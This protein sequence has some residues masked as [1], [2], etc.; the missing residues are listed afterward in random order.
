MGYLGLIIGYLII[1]LTPV[2]G[3]WQKAYPRMEKKST[4]AF[5][6]FYNYFVLLRACKLPWY[7]VIFL[8]FP[9]VQFIM[10]AALNV[11]YIR[12]F[13]EFGVKETILGILFPYPV[14]WKI[15]KNP[16]QYKVVPP[17]N[18]EVAKQVDART[19]SDHVALFFALP[20][21]GHAIAYP[22]SLLGV[23]KKE[24]K[25]SIFKEWGDA[26]LFAVIA[27]SVI[28]TY[29]FEPYKIPTGSME[30]T[31]LVG[32]HL[33]VDKLTFGPRVPMTPFSY[34]IVHN[35]FAP[36][37]NI[38]SYTTL[39]TIPYT[40]L[41]GWRDVERYDVVV[42]NFPAGDTAIND[43]R[44]PNG[45]I[46]HTYGQVLVD[47]AFYMAKWNRREFESRKSYY[48][49]KA[50]KQIR[51]EKLVLSNIEGVQ[52]DRNAPNGV[53][54][55][56]GIKMEG[57]GSGLLSRPVDKKE[58]Y[59]KRCVGLPGDLL[60][61]VN[62]VLYVNSK[63]AT[64][65]PGMQ[66]SG[67]PLPKGYYHFVADSIPFLP[68]YTDAKYFPIFPNDPQYDWTEDNFGPLKIP[69]AG[70]VVE[71]NHKTYPIYK[72]IIHAYEGH[73]LEEKADGIYIDG[74][75][76]DTY[77]IEMNYYWLMG[78]NRNN[79]ADSRFWGFVPEDH[80]VGHAAFIWL[81]TGPEGMFGGG[82]RW[83]RMFSDIE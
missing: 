62:Q 21:I 48:L 64:V 72:R 76:T 78:D 65:F 55:I 43:P 77:T 37:I 26:I 56:R 69:A 68:E 29:V 5:I 83:G 63:P 35:S 82:M 57:M 32:D 8:L 2:I 7:W 81:S 66:T 49:D 11:T 6:P 42:F 9:G 31:L 46:G 50:R 15:A 71:L 38:K 20:V 58:N 16:E 18:W 47:E 44:M 60:E 25:K 74:K 34:P 53:R 19:P 3:M 45:L 30:K 67:N 52:D 36:L 1:V 80:V 41:P 14:F 10:W 27:A 59:I 70:D 12:K 51:D 73:D 39:Q 4:D 79:S 75:K 13:G 54:I 61:V 40:R 33:F 23:K 28:R 22:F 24:G 17:T